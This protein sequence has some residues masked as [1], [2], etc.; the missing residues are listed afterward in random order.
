MLHGNPNF[1][2]CL[3]LLL[4][5]LSGRKSGKGCYIYEKGVKDRPVNTGAMELME[6]YAV[7]PKVI[8][9]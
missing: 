9:L 1:I 5:S 6:K 3:I 8:V 4:F 2:I 7:T